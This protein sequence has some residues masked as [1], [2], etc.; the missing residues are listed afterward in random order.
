MPKMQAQDSRF[1]KFA[2]RQ[3][4]FAEIICVN[5]KNVVPLHPLSRQTS[6]WLLKQSPL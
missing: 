1:A 2:N 3:A 4:V 5:E 6:I